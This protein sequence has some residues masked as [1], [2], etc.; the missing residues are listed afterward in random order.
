MISCKELDLLP[1]LPY[2][3]DLIHILDQSTKILHRK[4][5]PLVIVYWSKHGVNEATWE[6]EDEMQ[7]RFLN[8]STQ[9]MFK[10]GSSSLLSWFMFWFVCLPTFL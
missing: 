4:V 3:E 8:C 1:D 2:M 6:R 5:V 9:R 10:V 7:K